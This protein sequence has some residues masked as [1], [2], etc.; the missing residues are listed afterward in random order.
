MV[1]VYKIANS[2]YRDTV[3]PT[4][5]IVNFDSSDQDPSIYKQLGCQEDKV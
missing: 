4:A 2:S 3:E 1:D 5:R